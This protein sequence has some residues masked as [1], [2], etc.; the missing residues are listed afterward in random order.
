M[1]RDV[2]GWRLAYPLSTLVGW[3]KFIKRGGHLDS[4]IKPV[5]FIYDR[6]CCQVILKYK[7]LQS[8]QGKRNGDVE[9]NKCRPA[10]KAREADS[11]P[12][13]KAHVLGFIFIRGKAQC[14]L[15][16]YSYPEVTQ[17]SMTQLAAPNQRKSLPHSCED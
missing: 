3:H 16:S 7:E 13:L 10:C 5:R 4:V 8:S 11:A 15:L 1:T 6:S 14:C 12:C 17:R 9:E 2:H